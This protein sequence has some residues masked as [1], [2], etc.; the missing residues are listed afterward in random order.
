MRGALLQSLTSQSNE[1]QNLPFII[2]GLLHQETDVARACVNALAKFKPELDENLAN[3]LLSRVIERWQL[4]NSFEK[5]LVSLSGEQRPGFKMDADPNRRP[6]DASRRAAIEFWKNWYAQKFD[7]GFEPAVSPAITERT[8]QEI[9]A[10]LSSPASKGGNAIRGAKVY[11]VTQCNS[12]HGGG[13]TPGREGRIFGPDLAG[14]TRRLSLQEFADA[15][16]YPSKQIAD[17][18]KGLEIQT[19]AGAA[20]TGFITDQNDQVITFADREQVHR[21]PRNEIKSMTLQS[22]SLMPERLMNRLS[23]E[24]IRDLLAFLDEGVGPKAAETKR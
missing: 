13:V 16:V 11:E 18:F 6:D 14:V 5:A 4:L 17:R 7:H 9:Y 22:T 15:L 10:F 12:C 2:E 23:W 19:K 21:I 8:D 24:E 1:G 3:V 20:L